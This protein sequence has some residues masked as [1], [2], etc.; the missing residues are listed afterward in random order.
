MRKIKIIPLILALLMFASCTKQTEEIKPY[1]TVN[2]ETITVSEIEYFKKRDRADIINEF[3]S[4]YNV[5]DYSD[6]WDRSF[7]GETP[8]QALEKRAF[9]DAVKAKI[10]LILMRE[11]GI[12]DEISFEELKIK[13]EKFNESS[14]NGTVGIMSIDMESFYTYYVDTGRMELKNRLAEGEL[15]PS[16][17]EIQKYLSEHEGITEEGAVS[18]IVNEKF[19][20]YFSS[21]IEK[22]EIGMAEESN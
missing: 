13:A 9:D 20:E 3:S 2:G 4:E 17:A 14:K 6:F 16:Q 5:T 18:F 7:D 19:E 8:T 22:A 21:L 1:A 12:F 10:I 15:K 11:Q